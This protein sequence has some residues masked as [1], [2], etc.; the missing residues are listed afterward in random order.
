MWSSTGGPPALDLRQH[1]LRPASA[2]ICTSRPPGP[3]AG[4][5]LHPRADQNQNCLRR[6]ALP[7]LD[8]GCCRASFPPGA[9]GKKNSACCSV[10]QD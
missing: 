3:P 6:G 4:A 2:F 5:G 10:Q 1:D 8:E 9:S 7:V